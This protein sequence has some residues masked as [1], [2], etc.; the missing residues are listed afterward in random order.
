[1]TARN[2]AALALVL[3][4]ALAGAAQAERF[5]VLITGGRVVDGS[6]SPWFAADIGI[7]NGR[8]SRIGRLSDA[9]AASR[10]NASGLVVAPGFIDPHA[11]ARERLFE[12]PTAE[13]YAEARRCRSRRSSTRQKPAASR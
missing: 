5:D 11:H 13:G 10:V 7:V 6:G 1:M 4:A 2:L 8:I 12:L 3:T 9:S